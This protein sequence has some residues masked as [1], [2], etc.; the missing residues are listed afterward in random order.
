MTID[1]YCWLGSEQTRHSSFL[2]TDVVAWRELVCSLIAL[3]AVGAIKK[4][5][6]RFL[7]VLFSVSY[8]MNYRSDGQQ[9]KQ[10]TTSARLR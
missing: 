10:Q 9:Q 7:I 2:S 1:V 8:E 3:V 6:M 5:T 4:R